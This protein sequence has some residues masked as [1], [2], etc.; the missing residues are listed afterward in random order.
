M[1]QLLGVNV[2]KE[3][4]SIFGIM[5]L[6]SSA[7]IVSASV[8][9]SC[10]TF[11]PVSMSAGETHE[12]SCT[13]ENLESVDT[14]MYVRLEIEE[15]AETLPV[16]FGDFNVSAVIDS[17]I[18]ECIEYVEPNGTFSC[19]D[20]AEDIEYSLTTGEHSLK[21][22][23]TSEANLWPSEYNFTLAVLTT[24]VGVDNPN[25]TSVQTTSN[26]TG[27][28]TTTIN[29]T[30]TTD[31][32]E[33]TTVT[34]SIPNSGKKVNLTLTVL[35]G[36]TRQVVALGNE[37][38]VSPKNG[39]VEN[40]SYSSSVSDGTT[41][42]SLNITVESEGTQEILVYVGNLGEPDE[43]IIYS[44]IYH[45]TLTRGDWV[46]DSVAKT[47]TFSVEFASLINTLLKWI[48]PPAPPGPAPAPAGGGGGAGGIGPSLSV[49]ITDALKTIEQSAGSSSRYAVDVENTGTA[50][51]TFV[52]EIDELPDNY[53]SVSEPI[54][55][56]PIGGEK[57]GKLYYTLT[58]PAD[59]TG[60]TFRV[61]VK[62]T[63]G[64]L[65]A[66]E[67]FVAMLK[68]L[69]PG[70]V[71]TTTTTTTIPAATTPTLPT[72]IIPT[73]A[74]TGA[75]AAFSARPLV[76]IVAGGIGVFAA[77]IFVIRTVA[78]RKRTPWRTDYYKPAHKGKVL[79]SMKK[80]VKKRFEKEEWIKRL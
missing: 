68:I 28:W 43:I 49:K 1:L 23:V 11:L 35:P 24:E 26:T 5:V 8:D 71:P 65:T 54:T 39:T 27:E 74:I 36:V 14:S 67:S 12:I 9:F 37:L 78:R 4:W 10:D 57:A 25:V 76:R 77:G 60:W 61:T 40:V 73:G 34:V 62:G 3:I 58:L 55:L 53:Y 20:G 48:T 79:S 38:I 32:E 41:T 59:A 47:I 42:D 13:L 56:K 46:Y 18:L 52:L 69:P 50:D 2:R 15:T 70:A 21:L 33:N 80:Q 29:L 22:N 6:L 45:T 17:D 51:G 31:E 64:L 75:V 19:Y 16:W 72:V 44:G 63:A 7:T 66:S 30:T